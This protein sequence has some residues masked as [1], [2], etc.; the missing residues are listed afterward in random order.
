MKIVYTEMLDFDNHCNRDYIKIWNSHKI[1][2][3]ELII[4]Y[5]NSI[6]IRQN[7]SVFCIISFYLKLRINK[8]YNI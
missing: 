7:N 1:C 8:Y 4:I 3:E 5:I 6:V 2:L